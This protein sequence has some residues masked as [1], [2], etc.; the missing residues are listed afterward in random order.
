MRQRHRGDDGHVSA[1]EDGLALEQ[2]S[3]GFVGD[4]QPFAAFGPTALQ[5]NAPVLR[6][7][8]NKK[9]MGAAASPT[10]G[11]KSTFHWT[12]GWV[13][14]PWRN[15]NRNEP[16]KSVSMFDGSGGY[17]IVSFKD[18]VVESRAFSREAIRP[19]FSTPV[20]KTV[21]IRRI[22]ALGAQAVAKLGVPASPPTSLR[23]DLAVFS[24][25]S[26]LTFAV[27]RLPG[28]GAGKSSS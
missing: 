22:W 2:Q 24:R 17:R 5:D 21:E 16:R 20:E 18:R 12:P 8:P 27:H 13:S 4:G 1:L 23:P 28:P 11:L 25:V 3:A 14:I 15:S 7:H 26:G 9:P 19:K 10:I 6:V